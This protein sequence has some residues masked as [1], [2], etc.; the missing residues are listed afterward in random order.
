MPQ[1]HVQIELSGAMEHLTKTFAR[2]WKFIRANDSLRMPDAVL[3][4]CSSRRCTYHEL[5]R[6]EQLAASGIARMSMPDNDLHLQEV[7]HLSTCNFVL[8]MNAF[9]VDPLL[10]DTVKRWLRQKCP[11]RI[12]L[13][14]L[15][16]LSVWCV[17][18]RA[19]SG[20]SGGPSLCRRLI[21]TWSWMYSC[22]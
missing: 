16:C 11:E 10:Q 14:I 5:E 2:V 20:W 8:C 13:L 22:E 17:G 3:W 12:T 4:R 6:L 18:P 9:D 7:W 19:C 21:A 1:V 15:E